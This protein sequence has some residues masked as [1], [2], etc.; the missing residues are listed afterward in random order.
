MPFSYY[1]RLSARNQAIYRASE[2]VGEIRLPRPERLGPLC[3]SLRSALASEDRRAVAT[4]AR[5][6][7]DALLGQL[8]VTS[9]AVKV[10]AVRPSSRWGEL[11]GLYTASEK[12]PAEVR[13]WMR[14]VRH[15]Q[16]VAFRTF[17]RTLLH[18][19]GHHLDYELLGLQDSFHTEGFYR[20]ES[21]LF[22]QL[23]GEVAERRSEDG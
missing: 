14:T 16:V 13:L 17:L 21:S 2:R 18:E 23:L 7:S 4:A 19:L 3:Q 9:L 1:S 22:R 15:K 8:G 5:A 20:R 6:L 12:A 11:H 10:L